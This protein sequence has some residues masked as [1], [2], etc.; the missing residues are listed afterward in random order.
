MYSC[1]FSPNAEIAEFE[2]VLEEL[3]ED[4]I[5]SNK[6]AVKAMPRGGPDPP[7]NKMD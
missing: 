7:R 5:N 6:E 2:N 4:I 3:K 1:Y